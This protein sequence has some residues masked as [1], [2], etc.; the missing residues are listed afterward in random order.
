MNRDACGLPVYE[1]SNIKPTILLDIVP[2]RERE[3]NRENDRQEK[4]KR[5]DIQSFQ[6]SQLPLLSVSSGEE[7]G[8]TFCKH[9]V[10]ECRSSNTIT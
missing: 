2:Q 3:R 6:E 1:L 7:L 4:E 9:G 10:N 5:I 8:E